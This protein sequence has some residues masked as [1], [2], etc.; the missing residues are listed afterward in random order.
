MRL[1]RDHEPP[2][3]RRPGGGHDGGDLCRVVAVVVDDEHAVDFAVALETTFGAMKARERRSDA[4][5]VEADALTHGDRGEGVLK[6]VASGYGELDAAERLDPFRRLG[7][8]RHSA[9][10]RDQ[11]QRRWPGC[12]PRRDRGRRS[13]GGA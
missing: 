1:K 12:E 11:V 13:P 6:I 2:I 10:R 9:H 5:E 4:I 8:A 7:D 3:E